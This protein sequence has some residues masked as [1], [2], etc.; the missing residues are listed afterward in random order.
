MLQEISPADILVSET[1]ELWGNKVLLFNT[2]NLWDFVKTSWDG[3]FYVQF[4]QANYA[5]I[6]GKTLFLGVTV[7]MFQKRLTFE[8]VK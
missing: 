5:L 1:P 3:K 2:P 4:Y 7:R 8:S 6:S